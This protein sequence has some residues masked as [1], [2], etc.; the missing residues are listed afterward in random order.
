M[1]DDGWFGG[2]PPDRG[3]WLCARLYNV[4]VASGRS[5]Y[6]LGGTVDESRNTPRRH[7][8]HR[9]RSLVAKCH[10]NASD[11]KNAPPGFKA[12]YSPNLATSN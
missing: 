2:H 5:G 4:L 1:P 6:L 10:S 7:L 11:G 12:L 3:R 9:F 8:M